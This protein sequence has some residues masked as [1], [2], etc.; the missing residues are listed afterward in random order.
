MSAKALSTSSPVTLERSVPFGRSSLMRPPAFS[1]VPFRQGLWGRQKKNRAPPSPALT[2]ACAASPLPR[3]GGDRLDG[4]A[5]E[6][7]RQGVGGVG[8]PR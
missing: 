1:A 6:G 7:P 8:G 2:S 5:F 4:P 3:L